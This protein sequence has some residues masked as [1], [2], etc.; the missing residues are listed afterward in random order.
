MKKIFLLILVLAV[1]IVSCGDNAGDDNIKSGAGQTPENL[2]NGGETGAND[3]DGETVEITAQSVLAD[4]PDA[5]YGGYT[6][7]VLTSNL[8]DGAEFEWRQAPEETETG[9]PINDALFRRD[10]LIEE[11]YNIN[12]KYIIQDRVGEMASMA[13][14]TIRSGDNL[15]DMVV[16]EMIGVT[17]TLA[18]SGAVHDFLDFPNVDLSKPWWNQNAIRDL[19]IDNKFFFP[20]GDVTPR[21]V[22]GPYFLMFNKDLFADHGLDLPYEKVLDGTWTFDEFQKLIKDKTRDTNG[23]GTYDFFGMFNAGFSAYAFMKSFG[24][25]IIGIKDGNPFISVGNERSMHIIQAITDLLTMHDMYYDLNY[26]V[27]DEYHTFTN[28]RALFVGQTA[29]ILVMYRDMDDDFGIIPLPKFDLNQ[30][31]YYS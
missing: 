3:N 20:T 5:N 28:S 11:K 17:R 23:D 29:A 21:Y 8:N 31:S 27:F 12:I 19:M 16:G 15:F 24:E 2:Q 10:R 22:L 6:F 25:S 26:A 1:F 9:E 14:R 18:Q 30:E 4:L 7:T 13:Q